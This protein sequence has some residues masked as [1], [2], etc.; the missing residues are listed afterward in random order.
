M[1]VDLREIHGAET[2]SSGRE[3]VAAGGLVSYGNSIPDAYRSLV[4]APFG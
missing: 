2:I 1:K 4:M 3:W